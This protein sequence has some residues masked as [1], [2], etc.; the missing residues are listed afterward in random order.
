MKVPPFIVPLL[1]VAAAAGGVWGGRLFTV[2]SFTRDYPAAAAAARP[3]RVVLIVSGLKCVDTAQR[4][5]G[6]FEGISGVRQ[7]VLFASRNRAEVEF[8][9]ALT[10]V[11]ALRQAV[12]GP[13]HDPE[14]D[15]YLFNQFRVVS[16][17]EDGRN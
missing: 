8:D 4:L 13:V 15:S 5:A 6:Q 2:P 9:A 11:A 7:V 10:D 3:T 1:V 17:E 16:V 14:T 12:E